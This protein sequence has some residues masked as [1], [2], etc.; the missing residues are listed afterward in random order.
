MRI[1]CKSDTAHG[2]TNL[3]GARSRLAIGCAVLLLLPACDRPPSAVEPPDIDAGA[4][5]AAFLSELDRDGDRFVS[6][7]E[8]ESCPA[9]TNRFDA[10]DTDRDQRI[11]SDEMQTA[12]TSW[13]SDHIGVMRVGCMV[14]FNGQPLGGATVLLEPEG[15]LADALAPAQGV[16]NKHGQCSL[17]ID[18]A[19]LPASQ[20]RV[21]GVQP[22]LYRVRIT[23]DTIAIPARYNTN[24]TL[25]QEV[26]SAGVAPAGVTFNLMP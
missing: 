6:R 4:V 7:T 11:N 10:Y 21:R 2:N 17:S 14:T 23:H 16:T 24:T 18:P 1:R 12:V 22:G 15:V 13:T 8:A 26:S 25:G 9:V 19:S 5:A 20:Q 3:I